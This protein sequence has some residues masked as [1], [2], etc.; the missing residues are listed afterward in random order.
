MIK[1]IYRVTVTQGKEV[2]LSSEVKQEGYASMLNKV[3]V[4]MEPKPKRTIDMD[5][6]L[7]EYRVEE[8]TSIARGK[9]EQQY[10]S[11]ELPKNRAELEKAIREI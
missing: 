2:N 5:K 10:L 7:K 1:N 6:I 3:E 8:V 9:I 11:Q 4:K